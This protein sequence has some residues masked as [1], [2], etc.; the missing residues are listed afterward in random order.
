MAF[1]CRSRILTRDRI[2]QYGWRDGRYTGIEVL[3]LTGVQPLACCTASLWTYASLF[4]IKQWRNLLAKELREQSPSLS[5]FTA[6]A[7]RYFLPAFYARRNRRP[8]GG[9][10]HRRE[11]RFPLLAGWLTANR[12]PK[13]TVSELQAIQSFFDL[14]RERYGDGCEDELKKASEFA[15]RWAG[16]A[17]SGN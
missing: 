5:Y 15:Q 13:F 10:Y 14:C 4:T 9:G 1:F 2:G 3:F 8:Q 17:S 16:E 6:E 12:K 7:F 11:H